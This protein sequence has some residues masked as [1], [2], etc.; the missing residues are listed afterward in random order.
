MHQEVVKIMLDAGDRVLI[1]GIQ[2]GYS[3]SLK[4]KR[5][6]AWI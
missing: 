1:N 2:D 4:K 5:R 3:Q 6:N